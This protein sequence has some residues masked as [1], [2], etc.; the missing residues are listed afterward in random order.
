MG[1]L[2]RE[3]GGGGYGGFGWGLG[4]KKC[5]GLLFPGLEW[6]CCGDPGLAVRWG[7]WLCCVLGELCRPGLSGGFLFESF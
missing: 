5:L 6:S 1:L 7:L 4:E 2:G 3:P